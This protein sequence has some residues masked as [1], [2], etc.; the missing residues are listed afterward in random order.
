MDME[1]AVRL[2]EAG[3]NGATLDSVKTS[4]AIFLFVGKKSA[5]NPIM[6]QFDKG[7]FVYW[8]SNQVKGQETHR[9]ILKE[10]K[11]AVYARMFGNGEVRPLTVGELADARNEIDVPWLPSNLGLQD[12][13]DH[14]QRI[15][16]A[17]RHI[18]SA[19]MQL[20]WSGHANVSSDLS[21]AAE[22]V[23]SLIRRPT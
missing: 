6:A 2:A 17:A 7:A 19:S 22:R 16:Q 9:V 18:R 12:D 20:R 5:L 21:A 15:R 13:L 1:E 3:D 11:A 10:Q 4:M 23:E 14:D 8:R